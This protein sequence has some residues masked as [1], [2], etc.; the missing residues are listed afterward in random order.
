MPASGYRIFDG[1]LIRMPATVAP[2][3]SFV[4]GAGFA[5]ERHRELAGGLV[6]LFHD[7]ARHLGRLFDLGIGHFDQLDAGQALG[8]LG[9]VV[10]AVAVLIDPVSRDVER[11]R[12]P[13][14]V[15]RRGVV[16]RV[17][18]AGACEHVVGVVLLHRRHQRTDAVVAMAVERR[19]L[20][21]VIGGNNA[22]TR[23]ALL[24][25]GNLQSVGLITLDAHFDMRDTDEGLSNGNPVRALIEDG[26]P[27]ANVAQVGLAPFANTQ[28]MHRD[29]QDAGNFLVTIGEVRAHGKT[30]AIQRG[31]GRLFTAILRIVAEWWRSERERSRSSR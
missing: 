29:A 6:G 13:R 1:L 31:K 19:V 26:L 4:A 14:R 10:P 27:G 21:L 3:F 28:D 25:L 17:D 15:E 8:D 22:V 16:V 12:V 11:Q 30:G 23:P 2:F 20:T 5:G 24:A 7:G 9:D 18:V